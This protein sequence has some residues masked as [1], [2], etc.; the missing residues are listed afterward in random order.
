MKVWKMLGAL[1]LDCITPFV[2][3]RPTSVL[4]KSVSQAH[5]RIIT[6]CPARLLNNQPQITN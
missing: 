5:L 4:G 1:Q 6:F 3:P 2:V